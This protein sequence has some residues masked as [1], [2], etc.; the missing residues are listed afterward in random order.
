[1]AITQQSLNS[2]KSKA[3][4]FTKEDLAD[5]RAGEKSGSRSDEAL[6]AGSGGE[7]G[8]SLNFH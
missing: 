6:D 7:G 3:F 4:E 5:L 8:S 1:M 2:R